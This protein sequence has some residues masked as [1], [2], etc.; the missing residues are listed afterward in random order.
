MRLQGIESLK[1]EMADSIAR[2]TENRTCETV[3]FEFFRKNSAAQ[4]LLDLGQAGFSNLP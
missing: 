2:F 3:W 4:S 1:S